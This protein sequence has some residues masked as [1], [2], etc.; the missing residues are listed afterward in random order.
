MELLPIWAGCGISASSGALLAW[1]CGLRGWWWLLPVSMLVG[2][3]VTF[4]LFCLDDDDAE[5][6]EDEEDKREDASPAFEATDGDYVRLKKALAK[7]FHPDAWASATAIERAVREA[8]FREIWA[9]VDRIEG[10]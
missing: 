3:I 7:H 5:D 10:R 1:G 4:S 2:A 9:E 6:D 8:I